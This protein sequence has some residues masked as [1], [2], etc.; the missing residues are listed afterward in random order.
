MQIGGAP[1]KKSSFE[2]RGGEAI[3]VEPA[4]LTPLKAEPEALPV[5]I[6]YEDDLLLIINK[7]PALPVHKAAED[8]GRNLVALA[9]Q[10]MIQRETP[11]K[12][13][14]VN[15]L[16][17][18]TSGATLLA[19]S[20]TSAGTMGRFIKEEG[21]GK[22]YLAITEGVLPPSLTITEPLEG[23]EAET[24][25]T[26]LA[27][28][29]KGSLAVVF[30]RTGRTHQIRKHLAMVGHPILGDLRYGGPTVSGLVGHGLHAFSVS[31]RHPKA[32]AKTTVTAPLPAGLLRLGEAVAGSAWGDIL[33]KLPAIAVR[34]IYRSGDRDR[35]LSA[36]E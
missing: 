10:Y 12:L 4:N 27:T 20:A 29:D 11:L 9:E 34:D 19:K 2:L 32:G 35:L 31:F 3:D 21:L 33:Q 7:E 8:Q 26:T 28:G 13:R 36:E 30:P 1:Q 14:P 22:I 17:S 23:K 5:D 25:F 15:R 18:G 6:L 16:D 24:R